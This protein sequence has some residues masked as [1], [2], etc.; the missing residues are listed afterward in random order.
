MLSKKARKL[1]KQ[2]EKLILAGNSLSSQIVVR[3]ALELEDEL[4]KK[5]ELSATA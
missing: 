1:H 4:D 3:K 2:L 5:D